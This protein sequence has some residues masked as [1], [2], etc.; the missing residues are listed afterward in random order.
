MPLFPWRRA[1]VQGPLAHSRL[2]VSITDLVATY[3][4]RHAFRNSGRKPLEVV[5]SFPLPLD[6]AFLGLRACIAG[7][8]LQADVRPRAIAQRDYDDALADGHSA[9]LLEQPAPGLLVAS[10]GNLKPGEEGE[11]VLQFAA[12]LRVASGSARFSLPLVHRPRYGHWRLDE[13]AA[14]RHDF[15]ATHPLSLA[16]R[17]QGLLASANAR[18]ASHPAAFTHTGD[19]LALALHDAE[20]DRDLVLLFELDADIAAM[21]RCIADGE[22][23]FGIASVVIPTDA[24]PVLPL[25]LVLLLDGSGSMHGDAIKQSR[26]AL[27]AIA[28]ALDPADRIQ[29][30]RFGS[31][32]RPLFRRPLKGTPQVA[33]A[34]DELAATIDADLGGT[35]MGAALQAGLAQFPQSE[36]GRTRAIILVTDGAVQPEDIAEA[37]EALRQAGI[38]CFVV[39]VGSAAGVE[40]LEPLAAATRAMM[41]RA[42]PMEPIDACVMRQ[43]RR[44]RT[45]PLALAARW[46]GV[47]AEALAMP[48]AFPGDV[49]QV[50][51][52]WCGDAVPTLRLESPAWPE[53]LTLA[54]P[55]RAVDPAQR[56]ILGQRRHADAAP[57]RQL[58]IALRYGLMTDSTSAV[59][60][61]TRA[62]GDRVDELPDIAPVAQM[63]PHGMVACSVADF[64]PMPAFLRRDVSDEG[65]RTSIREPHYPLPFGVDRA[66]GA[67]HARDGLRSEHETTAAVPSAGAHVITPERVAEIL[68]AL[69]AVLR[70]AWLGDPAEPID[71]GTALTRLPEALRDD[72]LRIL[73]RISPSD[74]RSLGSAAAT[75]CLLEDRVSHRRLTDDEEARLAMLQGI[76]AAPETARYL[77]DVLRDGIGRRWEVPC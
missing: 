58:A 60:V 76:H 49:L 56:A 53:G 1:R 73:D 47:D 9:V 64:L 61:R 2:E 36:P 65:A 11:I 30:I 19:G 48:H 37:R 15:A 43:F 75:L 42:V 54:L 63:V 6:A 8:T 25:D 29:A 5:Y 44:A 12:P 21:A 17:V 13:P 14:P 67:E 52:H 40:V 51:A 3:T 69:F 20:L 55:A 72:A 59:L 62:D 28:R 33:V 57:G 41:E 34:L 32:T 26:A 4:L 22:D 39:A 70:H 31:S 27:R 66:D 68:A 18:C 45:R 50:A 23:S 71:L 10:L 77:D 74:S 38:A 35:E 16:V 24:A 7:D 46:E